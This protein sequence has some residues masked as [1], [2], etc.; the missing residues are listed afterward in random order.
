MGFVAVYDACVLYPAPLRDLL[1][2]IGMTGLVQAKWTND[3]LDECFHAILEHHRE[4][5]L[6]RLE[7]TRTLM[8]RAIRDVL[9]DGYQGLVDTLKLPDP[10]DR[11]VLAAA[12]RCGAQCIVTTNLKHF[13]KK[14]L[15][16][17]DVQALHP[18]E[19][20]LDLLDLAP[21]VILKVL[22]QQ[23]QALKNPPLEL[24]D[25][26]NALENNGLVQSMAEVRRLMAMD[27]VL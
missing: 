19:F 9:V 13:P 1:V 22:D 3:I 8:N 24:A 26:L 12:I 15:A 10:K 7:R 21:G 18:D 27:G 20:I 14:A 6:E 5:T 11:H 25:V 4:L 17:F 23:A 16:P 2:R